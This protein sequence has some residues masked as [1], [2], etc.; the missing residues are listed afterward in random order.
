[1]FTKRLETK[2]SCLFVVV[3]ETSKKNIGPFLKTLFVH[4]LI[5]I[6]TNFF[7]IIRE[8]SWIK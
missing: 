3:M 6:F 4:E 5:R 7:V 1:M 8:N 2:F